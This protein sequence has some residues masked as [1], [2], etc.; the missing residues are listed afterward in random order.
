M[1]DLAI[2]EMNFRQI[3]ANLGAKIHLIHCGELPGEIRC[4]RKIALQGR[5]DRN[6]R[7]RRRGGGG[8]GL[9]CCCLTAQY[10]TPA[11]ASK[12]ATPRVTRPTAARGYYIKRVK[13]AIRSKGSEWLVMFVSVR[14]ADS[15]GGCSGKSQAFCSRSSRAMATISAKPRLAASPPIRNTTP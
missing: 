8:Y 15:G 12:A 4:L 7:A 10:P 5:A 6:G 3:A 14:S 13:E 2:G 1:D 11:T 9:A